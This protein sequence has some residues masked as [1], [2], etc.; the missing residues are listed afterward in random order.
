[1]NAMR[2]LLTGGAGYL[3][4][5][6]T[7]ML[8]RL[9][10]QVTVIDNLSH[11]GEPLLGLFQDENFRFVK[12]DIRNDADLDKALEDVDAVVHLAAIVG[13]PACARDP[14][15][16]REVNDKGSHKLFDAAVKRGVQRFIF[17]STCSNYGKMAE[18]SGFLDE[19]SPL[20][21]VSL[22]AETKVAVEKTLLNGG[23]QRGPIVTVL[24][25]STLYGLSP[26]MRFDLTV[27][28]FTRDLFANRKLVVFGQQFWRP[29]VH[30]SD[31][32]R[33]ILLVLKSPAEKVS[34]RVFNV[35]DSTQNYQKGQLVEMIKSQLEFDVDIQTV[36]K[37]EDPRDYRVTFTRI[38][39]ELGFKISR[40][41][42]D[43]IREVRD[44]I[45]QGVISDIENPKYKNV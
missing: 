39:D 28:E 34:G 44:A 23:S 22:Y 24:R 25:C 17:T 2:I 33:A 41:V 16:A 4:S 18:G 36:Q 14:E 42:E 13:D 3:G 7:P 12:G 43:G 45:E 27:N 11:G 9:G 15:L 20:R 40:T 8:L 37:Q 1:M 5:V 6:L 26:R 19:T 10:Y 35:G 21:P 38:R 30:V 32:A 31:A 29:Y